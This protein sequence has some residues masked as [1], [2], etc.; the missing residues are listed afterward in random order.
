MVSKITEATSPLYAVIDL[1]SNS[2]H[3]LITRQVAD[4]VQIVDKIKRKVR[5]ASGLDNNNVLSQEAIARGIECLR[6]FAERLQ[7]IPLANIRIVAT[8]TVRLATN[9]DE[10]LQLAQQILGQEVKLLS[11]IQE[12][13]QIYLGVAHTSSGTEKERL[14]LDIGGASTELV[15]GEN[16]NVIN[17]VSIDMGCVTFNQKFFPGG[18][19]ALKNFELAVL[20][21]QNFLS[22]IVESYKAVGW[23]KALSGSGTMQALAEILKHQQKPPVVTLDFLIEIRDL[24]LG[25]NNISTLNIAGLKEERVP[26]FVSGLAILIALFKSLSIKELQLSSGALREGLLYEMLTDSHKLSIRTRTTNG[27]INRFNIDLAHAERVAKQANYLYSQINRPWGLPTEDE[28]DLLTI[29]C[30]LHEIGLLLEFKHHQQHGAYI[31]ENTELPGFEPSERQLLVTLVKH[32]KGDI[33]LQSLSK[34]VCFE[35]QHVLYLLTIIRVAVVLCRRRMD[36]VLPNYQVTAAPNTLTLA[37]PS[38]WLNE[39][40]LLHDELRQEISALA[41][42][43]IDLKILEV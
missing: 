1:G 9:R 22:P 37:L 32:Y 28:L 14:V 3:M 36:D 4:S 16:F 40:P 43:D 27:L 39:H 10:F 35:Q 17:A 31:L 11:G 6:F 23:Q 25:Y 12:A 8:A 2:F 42:L 26:V 33:D 24:C 30:L 38:H 41:R 34:H 5:L 19:L 29:A 15:I 7:D 21:A 18:E 20:H 13:Q